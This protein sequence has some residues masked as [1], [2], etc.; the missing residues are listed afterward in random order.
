MSAVGDTSTAI[1]VFSTT[2]I[3]QM[4]DSASAIGRTSAGYAAYGYKY[5]MMQVG[6]YTYDWS[7]GLVWSQSEWSTTDCAAASQTCGRAMFAVPLASLPA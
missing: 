5:A 1:R 2:H 6:Y 4:T 3:L 7:T